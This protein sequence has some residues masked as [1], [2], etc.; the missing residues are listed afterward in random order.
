MR[1]AGQG[2]GEVAEEVG[3]VEI[4]PEVPGA[5]RTEDIHVLSPG[6]TRDKGRSPSTAGVCWGRR[7]V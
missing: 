3:G 5:G 2:P 6:Q 7:E 4:G 1:R